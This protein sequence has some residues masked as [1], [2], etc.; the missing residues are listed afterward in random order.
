MLYVEP[1]DHTMQTELRTILD[2]ELARLPERQRAP[3]VLC[4]LEGLSRA[5]PP[6]N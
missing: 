4:E 1:P 2:D 6:R 5:M 3:I